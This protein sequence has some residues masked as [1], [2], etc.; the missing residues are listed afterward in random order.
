MRPS[1][2]EGSDLDA[3]RV[4]LARGTMSKVARHCRLKMP[5]AE[6]GSLRPQ[7][8]NASSF[9]GG[10]IQR[11]IHCRC[12][13]GAKLFPIAAL[14]RRQAYM[15]ASLVLVIG[16]DLVLSSDAIRFLARVC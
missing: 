6:T 4:C 15:W 7:G 5:Q 16:A 9:G 14:G 11:I 8:A 3:D 13:L 2:V 12:E 10:G 1:D